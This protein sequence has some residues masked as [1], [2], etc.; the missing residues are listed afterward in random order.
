MSL[1]GSLWIATKDRHRLMEIIH[2]MV[3]FGFGDLVKRVGLASLLDTL[4]L[5]NSEVIEGS[6]PERCRLAIESLGPTFTKLGQ[7]LSTRQDLLPPEWIVELEK[8]QSHVPVL[9][10]DQIKPV[11]EQELDQSIDAVFQ[12]FPSTPLAAGSIAQV[13]KTQ[14][15][16]GDMVVVKVRRPGIHNIIAAD[17]RLLAHMAAV[18]EH[19]S[20]E[21]TRYRLQE[22]IHVLGAALT[23]ELDLAIEARN[24]ETIAQQFVDHPHI[25]IPRI[26]TAFSTSDLLVQ[27]YID[28]IEPHNRHAIEQA[29][30]DGALLAKRGAE[31]FLRMA[32][33]DGVFHADP[34]P[35]NLRAMTYNGIG[36]ID[37][38]MV[39]RIGP[40]RR[41]Q[42]LMAVEAIVHGK[43]ERLAHVLLEW[44]GM[45]T[46]VDTSRLEAECDQ[47][48]IRYAT[49]PLR[50][51]RTITELMRMARTHQLTLPSDLAILFKAM[52]TADG[53]MHHLDPDF[54]AISAAAPTI[55]ESV[56]SQYSPR[57]LFEKAQTFNVQ[58]L[59]LAED[60]PPLLKLVMQRVRKGQL[61]V[62]IRID[63]VN[64]LDSSLRRVGAKIAVAIVTAAFALGLSPM[65]LAIGPDING[66][67]LTLIIG[68]SIVAMGV[69]W[70]MRRD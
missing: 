34:H 44:S 56:M 48:V 32:L 38:G 19:Y 63:N 21:L 25:T 59:S 67:P 2:V 24:T 57:A 51:G 45:P 58:L 62:S 9:P 15:L 52:V 5:V 47:F 36:F 16:S 10:W 23:E 27:E 42:L 18:A 54:D 40:K 3:R 22:V 30:L 60:L 31:A 65:L 6:A 12:H 61:Q 26:Y 37:F 46:D 53:V 68:L 50:L 17:L 8:L 55:A 29:G 69:A 70:V 11:I 39:G 41:E 1:M 66:T 35:G 7:I 4:P 20:T 43:G 33:V 14:L 28:G 49:P 13:Y 64:G